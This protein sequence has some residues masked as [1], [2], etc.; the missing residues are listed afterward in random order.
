MSHASVGKVEGIW[1][2]CHVVYVPQ[3]HKFRVRPGRFF[4]YKLEAFGRTEHSSFESSTMDRSMVLLVVS[5]LL[6]AS[7]NFSTQFS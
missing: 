4:V 6:V 7:V 3:Q 5:C 1:M 2:R